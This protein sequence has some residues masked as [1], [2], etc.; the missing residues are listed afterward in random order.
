MPL[1]VYVAVCCAIPEPIRVT[2]KIRDLAR[3]LVC[4]SNRDNLIVLASRL[5]R[6]ICSGLKVGLPRIVP[7]P[8]TP[9]LSEAARDFHSES[10]KACGIKRSP[11][12][13]ESFRVFV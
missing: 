11:G 2:P 7:T 9:L 13:R 8:S 3:E 1:H 4:F 6:S 10:G 5:R 12:N